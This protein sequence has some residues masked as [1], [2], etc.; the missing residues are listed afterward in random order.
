M[1]WLRGLGQ[2]LIDKRLWPIALVLG[3]AIIAAPTVLARGGGGDE[4]ATAPGATPN[5]GLRAAVVQT[6]EPGDG[7]A[8]GGMRNPFFDPPAEEVPGAETQAAGAATD[9]KTSGTDAGTTTKS[10][11]TST[12]DSGSD[13][14]SSDSGSGKD[15]SGDSGSSDDDSGSSTKGSG[16][17]G[18]DLTVKFGPAD[19]EIKSYRNVPRLSPLPDA[20]NPMFVYMGVLDDGKTAVFLMGDGIGAAVGDGTCRPSAEVCETLELDKGDTMFLDGAASAETGQPVQY[21]L[22]VTAIAKRG[23]STKASSASKKK[24]KKAAKAGRAAVRKARRNGA[25]DTLDR[26]RFDAADGVIRRLS[27]KQR[28]RAKAKASSSGALQV[29][30]TGRVVASAA[31]Q[32]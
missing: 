6:A 23:G 4:V 16:E 29:R 7:P 12:S 21:Q 13:S 32:G 26:Y 1:S 8:P 31:L 9:T 30:R 15:T 17:T 25:A 10:S 27:A 11:G 5:Q 20:E 2:D 24:A 19:G 22:E 28:G 3:I 18:Y 14:G